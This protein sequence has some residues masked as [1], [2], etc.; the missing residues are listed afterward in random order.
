MQ[1]KLI[2]LAVASLAAGSAFAQSNVTISGIAAISYNNYKV[3]DTTRAAATENRLDDNTSRFIIKGSEDLGGGL[4]AYFAFENRVSLDTRPNSTYGNAQGLGDGESYVGLKHKDLGSVGFGKFAFHYHEAI[5]YSESYRALQTQMYASTG[6][7]GQ[8]GFTPLGASQYIAG[9]TRNQNAIKYD[10]P[11]WNGFSAKIAYSFSAFGNEGTLTNTGITGGASN[12]YG[13][14]FAAATNN[15]YNKGYAWTTA[16][17]Y[18]NG[19]IN[20][21]LSYYRF[22][23]ENNTSLAGQESWKLHGDYKFPFGLKVGLG[24]DQSK[25]EGATTATDAKRTAWMIPLSYSFGQHAVYLTYAK[26]NSVKNRSGYATTSQTGARQYTLAYDYA[27]SKRTYAGVSYVNL[28]NDRNAYYT[29]WLAG[30]STLGGSGLVAGENAR[31]FSVNMTHF[32]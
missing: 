19:P 31:I 23:P 32:F 27:F 1:K 25:V 5:G 26:A 13:G 22:K 29:P 8:V 10:T 16:G 2:A 28:A 30:I 9:S 6:I 11:N 17:R 18:N 21:L 14:T 15:Q 24:F 20:V 4:S 12:Q 7:L 3:S